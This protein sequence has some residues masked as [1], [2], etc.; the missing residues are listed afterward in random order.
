M[1]IMSNNLS[2]MI[3]RSGLHKKDVG[4]AIGVAPETVSR[5]MSGN[6]QINLKLAEEYAKVLSCMPQDILFATKPLKILM[7]AHVHENGDISRVLA[8]EICPR[9]KGRARSGKIYMNHMFRDKLSAIVWTMDKDYTGENEACRD[10]IGI[11]RSEPIQQ[12]YVDEAC[13]KR[14]CYFL[15]KNSKGQSADIGYGVLYAEPGNVFTVVDT[16]SG[17]IRRGLELLWATPHISTVFRPDLRD[18]NIVY[19]K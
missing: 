17:D 6:I 11:V 4:A 2:V 14:P 9:T 10:A 5:H 3:A 19:D 16:N 1:M 15:A 8:G 12:K 18:M 7:H 13:E